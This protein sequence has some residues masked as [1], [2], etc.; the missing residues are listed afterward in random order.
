MSKRETAKF[1]INRRHG[2][3]HW[4]RAKSPLNK[5]DYRPGQHGQRRNKLSDFGQ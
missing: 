3:N 2:C 5:R 4:G 1:K